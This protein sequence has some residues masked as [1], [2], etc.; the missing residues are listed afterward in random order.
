[1]ASRQMASPLG[2]PSLLDAPEAAQAPAYGRPLS[3]GVALGLSAGGTLGAWGLLIIAGRQSYEKAA[4][5]GLAGT[6]VTPSLGHW[7]RGSIMTRGFALRL[8]AA[9]TGIASFV[10]IIGCECSTPVA[11]K[12]L[13][14]SAVL[15][16]GASIDDILTAPL[17]VRK[18]NRR[19]ESLGLAPMVTNHAVGLALSG[20]F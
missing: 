10:T 17:A 11:D 4:L 7:Y 6:L 5:V 9:A 15:Y 16:V 18:H 3:E 14:G 20:R 13:I 12:I 1:M 8:L 2:P 19:I